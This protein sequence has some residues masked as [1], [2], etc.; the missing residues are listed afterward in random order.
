MALWKSDPRALVLKELRYSPD[1]VTL[2]LL[3]LTNASPTAVKIE[4]PNMPEGLY[5]RATDTIWT[6]EGQ[7]VE[8][9]SYQVVLKATSL[10]DPELPSESKIWDLTVEPFNE[11]FSIGEVK[12]GNRQYLGKSSF[13]AD[14][15]TDT[16]TF[17][18]NIK[19]AAFPEGVAEKINTYWVKTE[20]SEDKP[21]VEQIKSGLDAS[22][23]PALYSGH[24]NVPKGTNLIVAPI[25]NIPKNVK[26]ESVWMV[27]EY[28]GTPTE[29]L[30][31]T[32]QRVLTEKQFKN[33]YF[34]GRYLKQHNPDNI[35]VAYIEEDE[36]GKKVAEEYLKV[37][38]VPRTNLFEC[39]KPTGGWTKYG[40]TLSQGAKKVLQDFKDKIDSLEATGLRIKGIQLCGDW[41]VDVSYW[42]AGLVGQV[43]PIPFIPLLMIHRLVLKYIP[44]GT[45]PDKSTSDPTNGLVGEYWDN[46]TLGEGF[47]PDEERWDLGKGR[48][49][50]VISLDYEEYSLPPR[51]RTQVY[52]VA[53][54]P[55]FDRPAE[56]YAIPLIHRSATI[57]GRYRDFGTVILTDTGTS[58]PLVQ[59]FLNE[60]EKNNYPLDNVFYRDR[61]RNKNKLYFDDP[62][63]HQTPGSEGYKSASNIG[64]FAIGNIGEDSTSYWR[65]N[66][67]LPSE[68]LQ[69]L[70]PGAIATYSQSFP[71]RATFALA[72]QWDKVVKFADNKSV[73]A[74]AR[75]EPADAVR[76]ISEETPGYIH[77]LWRLYIWT[78]KQVETAQVETK[79]NYFLIIK[80]NGSEVF[81]IDIKD[82]EL[83]QWF[84]PLRNW[85]RSNDWNFDWG[86]SSGPSCRGLDA[87][88]AGACL[89]WGS[90]QEPG[91]GND[92]FPERVIGCFV[93][94]VMNFSEY[95]Y[96][97]YYI[98]G[99]PRLTTENFFTNQ[100]HHF[101]GDL[102][103][104]PFKNLQE[105]PRNMANLNITFD[106]SEDEGK[107]TATWLDSTV[108][109]PEGQGSLNSGDP[110]VGDI[111]IRGMIDGEERDEYPFLLVSSD[112]L[113]HDM[114]P[115]EAM[116]IIK[117]N[118]ASVTIEGITIDIQGLSVEHF[119]I[120][121]SI[122]VDTY[123][124]H[125]NPIPNQL[126]TTAGP[127]DIL[128]EGIPQPTID[129]EFFTPHFIMPVIKELRN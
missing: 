69:H 3:A 35:L 99:F 51:E 111:V 110:V 94:S 57:E 4:S 117:A 124:I 8:R 23:K 85:L 29:V 41:P 12:V 61:D 104:R 98:R 102:L 43:R 17:V 115:Q 52:S 5:L 46:H 65:T 88:Q 83:A 116:E 53:A 66:I 82:K 58:V 39:P 71:L 76:M 100:T 6:I 67:N 27:A 31:G 45:D 97:K 21:T 64:L 68:G 59:Y 129:N 56:R 2:L 55:C 92:G 78:D 22:G 73:T 75:P 10:T 70:R 33:P 123:G 60:A 62:A 54:I 120:G 47:F 113:P 93:D 14:P 90:A 106:I 15:K 114:P 26:S 49:Q 37:R 28:N 50:E 121:P 107:I 105:G 20:A 122:G 30:G 13:F 79:D 101:Y 42:R 34:P 9:G 40:Q 19:G 128:V 1:L 48:G 95:I 38:K 25:P 126:I 36:E 32:F 16:V 91:S 96:H 103:Y 84:E 87:I 112:L 74:T 80:E 7:P 77:S 72:L 81:S 108:L 24:G 11:T 119:E 118:L 63:Y 86:R 89:T 125:L 44:D 109:P 18:G 127:Y